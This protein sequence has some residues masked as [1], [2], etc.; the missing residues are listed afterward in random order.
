MTVNLLANL[1]VKAEQDTKAS[2]LEVLQKNSKS[3]EQL[4]MEM[5][6]STTESIEEIQKKAKEK[7]EEER[8]AE[9]KNEDAVKVSVGSGEIQAS[10]EVPETEPVSTVEVNA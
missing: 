7:A 3:P 1:G 4:Q 2:W 8:K 6:K 9:A 10:S 5:L